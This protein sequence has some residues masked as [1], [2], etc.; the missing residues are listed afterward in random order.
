MYIIYRICNLGKYR[1]EMQCRWDIDVGYMDPLPFLC[2][3]SSALVSRCVS[4]PSLIVSDQRRRSWLGFEALLSHHK[5][6]Q[7]TESSKAQTSSPL[8]SFCQPSAVDEI[9]FARSLFHSLPSCIPSTQLLVALRLSARPHTNY[10]RRPLNCLDST[11]AYTLYYYTSWARTTFDLDVGC[12]HTGH[13]LL[14]L[15]DNPER[16]LISTIR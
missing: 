6:T 14:L 12:L 5:E 4:S 3:A 16:H 15:F 10:N 8:P 2:A 7:I 9:L 11:L 1:S 13:F